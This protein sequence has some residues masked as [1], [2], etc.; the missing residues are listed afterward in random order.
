MNEQRK[1]IGRYIM[2]R[3]L[4][5]MQQSGCRHAILGVASDNYPALM[6]YTS[7]GYRTIYSVFQMSK[8][9]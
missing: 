3:S 9:K 1:G 7:M 4:Y 8:S 5:E 2:E 6:L